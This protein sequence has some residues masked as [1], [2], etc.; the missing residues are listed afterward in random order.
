MERGETAL[1]PVARMLGT[2][3][4]ARPPERD[5]ASMAIIP[6]RSAI[7]VAGLR[8]SF[9][10]QV[11]LDGIDLEV[12]EGALLG[13]NGAGKT[14]MVQILTT[15]I[16]A[17]AGEVAVGGHDLAQDQE[18]V[19]VTG[20]LTAVDNLLSGEENLLLMA[21]LGHLDTAAG[22]QRTAELLEHSTWPRRP[23]SRPVPTRYAPAAGS[24]HGPDRRPP[25][26]LPG[27]AHRRP[28]PGAAAA[29]CGSSSATWSPAGPPSS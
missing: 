9:G 21:D 20:Q 24:G 8:K 12:A 27:R 6:S 23:A 11:V 2:V 1:N 25:D 5:E 19:E 10:E 14:T 16:G 13:P 22:R 17:D 29:P 26:R 28:G 18:G 3:V 7:G 4:A 15:L